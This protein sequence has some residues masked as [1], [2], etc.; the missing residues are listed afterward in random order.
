MDEHLG[1]AASR[2]SLASLAGAYGKRDKDWALKPE[3]PVVFRPGHGSKGARS[4]VCM[5]LRVMA[6]N[7]SS[8]SKIMI[9]D[10]K[11]DRL[12]WQLWE[13][14]PRPM[15][16]HAW[17]LLSPRLL[18]RS[19]SDAWAVSSK[20]EEEQQN[21]N[22]LDIAG[23]RNERGEITIPMGMYR[24]HQQIENPDCGLG[25]YTSPLHELTECLVYLCIDNL[26]FDGH[27]LLSL[28][29][30]NTLAVLELVERGP[31]DSHL[32]DSMIRGWSEVAAEQDPF[33]ELRIL[34][35]ASSWH[36]VTDA[37]LRHV[38][39]F[40]K[41]E[42]FE[43]TRSRPYF[44]DNATRI[45]GEFGW[46]K[47]Y[48]GHKSVFASLAAAYLDWRLRISEESIR[49]LGRL[50]QDDEQEVT[51]TT[52]P[53][54]PTCEGCKAALEGNQEGKPE[55]HGG[56]ASSGPIHNDDQAPSTYLDEGWEL[57]LQD[58]HP[59]LPA[60]IGKDGDKSNDSKRR[61]ELYEYRQRDTTDAQIFWLL[62]LLAQREFA[63]HHVGIQPRVEGIALP[64]KRF[65]SIRL[66]RPSPKIALWCDQLVFVRTSKSHGKV[67]KKAKD[68]G[69]DAERKETDL[70]PRKRQNLG[71]VF[72]SLGVS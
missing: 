46:N 59:F 58:N 55:K 19:F 4:L 57:L 14:M 34:R 37:S 36:G 72:A 24:Y 43:V 62:G 52:D 22:H 71:D 10:V 3:R 33:P 31:S 53:R 21:K 61:Q 5:C 27:G 38:L 6:E 65:A 1:L 40:P 47:T 42:V 48:A 69:K 45:A 50:F 12:L 9:G 11:E 63:S 7:I 70:R 26:E 32:S 16:L 64:R 13:E 49:Y 18:K 67:A 39:K 54:T 29:R 30:L 56:R 8:I 41:L 2:R 28:A 17:E 60:A 35:I 51:L 23:K 44:W 15:S 68:I 20:G 66:R 25:I